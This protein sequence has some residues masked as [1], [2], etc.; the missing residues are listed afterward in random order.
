[1]K[2]ATDG[3]PAVLAR[4]ESI[5]SNQSG[6][7]I[8]WSTANCLVNRQTAHSILRISA[9]STMKTTATASIGIWAPSTTPTNMVDL[10]ET[11]E[12]PTPRESDWNDVDPISPRTIAMRSTRPTGFALVSSGTIHLIR[13]STFAVWESGG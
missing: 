13:L 3:R 8:R 9:L 4:R 6:A 1:P 7:D 12:F 5:R 11:A 2:C 10:S